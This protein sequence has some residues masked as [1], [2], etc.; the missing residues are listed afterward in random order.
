[1]EII[2]LVILSLLFLTVAILFQ[3]RVKWLITTKKG[4]GIAG[5]RTVSYFL[6]KLDK[7][8]YFTINDITLKVDGRTSQIDHIVFTILAKAG[9]FG[10]VEKHASGGNRPIVADLVFC[11]DLTGR[12]FIAGKTCAPKPGI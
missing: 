5:E 6:N 8:K 4:K 12:S 11:E 7:S 1:M 10:A 9:L 3:R 2:Y